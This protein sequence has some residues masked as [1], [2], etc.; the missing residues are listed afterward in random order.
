MGHT[1]HLQCKR[2]AEYEAAIERTTDQVRKALIKER[3]SRK[4]AQLGLVRLA[5]LCKLTLQEFPGYQFK[6]KLPRV[7]KAPKVEPLGYGTSVRL[8]KKVLTEL[9]RGSLAEL[10]TEAIRRGIITPDQAEPLRQAIYRLERT[11]IVQ[12]DT[13]DGVKAFSLV[14]KSRKGAEAP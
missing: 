8:A 2:L 6:V 7:V 10:K 3:R 14:A 12:V 4:S 1:S 13:E 5:E 9:R 11:G